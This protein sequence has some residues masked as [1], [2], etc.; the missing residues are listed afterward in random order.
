MS[1]T[2]RFQ[3]PAPDGPQ[4]WGVQA[5][6]LTWVEDFR[7]YNGRAPRVLGIG[8]IANNAMRNAVALRSYGVE[9]DV[10]CHNY[11]HIMG[12]PEWE[13]AYF[14]AEGLDNTRP[15]WGSIDLGGYQRPRWF[16]Q[17]LLGTALDYLI[18]L[19][20]DASNL[21]ML[22]EAMTRERADPGAVATTV[23]R[24]TT[25]PDDARAVAE[26]VA[27]QFAATFPH[28]RDRMTADEVL[29]EGVHVIEELPRLRRLLAHYD[30][31]I[32]Y[33]TD[34]IIPLLAGTV[35]YVAYEHGTIRRIPFDR[36]FQGRMCAL[37]YAKA[38]DV[39][40][41]NADNIVAA[42][43]LNLRSFRY[44][45]HAMLETH[46]DS[47][48]AAVRQR[49]M[50]DHDA[51][52]IV[53]HPSRHHWSQARNPNLEKG[54]DIL[55]EAF[56][57]LV[58][59]VRPKALLVLASWGE[60]ID[61]SRELIDRL[62]IADRIAWL[63]PLPMRALIDHIAASDVLADQ[64]TIGAWG[65]IMPL[66]LMMGRPNLIHLVDGLHGWSYPSMPRVVNAG[67]V[68]G[69][70]RGLVAMTDPATAKAVGDAGKAWYDRYHSVSVVAARI[71]DSFMA[72]EADEFAAR[73][74]QVAVVTGQF[75]APA[76]SAAAGGQ[77]LNR[78]SVA[79]VYGPADVVCYEYWSNAGAAV[80]T[81]PAGARITLPNVPWH[82]AAGLPL[83]V[84]GLD[85]GPNRAWVRARLADVR[86][87]VE[88]C[89]YRGSDDALLESAV[90]EGAPG[91]QQ[92]LLEI[93]DPG[94]S[95]LLFRASE[96][97]QGASAVFLSAEVVTLPDYS[98]QARERSGAPG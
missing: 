48:G 15:Q 70:Y 6:H 28:R 36:N 67:D 53:L 89:L 45:P 55:I 63:P 27:A 39:L 69:V 49:L 1:D 8:N 61:K 42:E 44:V 76:I 47:D 74:A 66:G 54:N 32:A 46:R 94:I 98:P 43:R 41:T 24:E 21:D 38:G 19:R 35:G 82:Y 88:I 87:Q 16:A 23:Y 52:F 57:R 73:E 85:L 96:K 2:S 26:R 3:S 37:T 95:L 13:E 7:R 59:E 72:V 33:A 77:S 92:V 80:D 22:W 78:A 14:D 25:D 51:D 65:G 29:A 5:A 31:V 86:G 58:K 90:I 62:G 11:W 64:F 91:M 75:T 83:D 81:G 84:A 56:A 18:S 9:C 97:P 34:G 79:R 93:T 50:A 17:G 10:L 12:C 20:E 68:D 71:I 60:T 30:F 4:D 40:I